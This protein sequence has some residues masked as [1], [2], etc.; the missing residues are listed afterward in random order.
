MLIILL[1][2]CA[3][4]GVGTYFLLKPA[5]TDTDSIF[6]ESAAIHEHDIDEGF[7]ENTDGE[8]LIDKDFADVDTLVLTN[9]NG[10]FTIKRDSVTASL[11]V[12]EIDHDVPIC[13]DYL[14]YVW[15]YAYCLG[16]N[17][18]I[19]STSDVPV[20]LSDYGLDDPA[21]DFRITYTDG[22]TT[23]F[24]FGDE[25]VSSDSVYYF[26]FDGYDNTVFITEMSLAAFQGEGYFIDTDFFGI[27]EE[28]DDI[29][30][31]TIEITGSS[32]PEKIV[33]KPYSSSDRSDQSYG[34]SH[35]ITSPVKTAVNDVNATALV[36]E[37]IYLMAD[38]AICSKP[39]KATLAEYG[40]DKPALIITFERNGKKQVLSIGN[41]DNS[42]YCYATIKGL[43]V[44]YNLLPSDAEA[45]LSS[46][47]SYY[48]TSELRLYRINSVESVTVSFNDESYTFTASRTPLSD[49]DEYYEYHAYCGDNELTLDYYRDFLSVISSAYAVSWDT[50]ASSDE[51]ALTIKVS[52][53]DSFDRSD[54][55]LEF[56]ESDYG[57]FVCSINGKKTASVSAIFLTKVMKAARSLAVNEAVAT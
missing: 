48:R 27:S 47:L 8:L 22:T 29:E 38:S 43:D 2:V 45:I 26:T 40:L 39:D 10:T 46:S 1:C 49:D 5:D 21:A 13:D 54:D 53:F 19:V 11:Y 44:I 55:V 16:Y 7:I 15:Y 32:I 25:L 17:Y 23:H 35:I 41:T 30:I 57:R 50:A 18:K 31:G 33:I 56:Y 3:V 51:A 20:I 6:S 24:S 28:E 42:T 34:H 12:E 4:L 37:L 52:H 36:N 9:E 14:E